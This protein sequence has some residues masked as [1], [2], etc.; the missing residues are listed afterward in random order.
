MLG[1]IACLLCLGLALVFG[2]V[3]SVGYVLRREC[4]N[5]LGRCFDEEAGI[6]TAQQ[7]GMVWFALAVLALAVGLLLAW[8][9]IKPKG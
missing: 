9:W 1:R 4:F 6:V 2:Y 7:A 8:R 3:F 5:E